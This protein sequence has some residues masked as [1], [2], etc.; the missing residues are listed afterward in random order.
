MD[1]VVLLCVD[2]GESAIGAAA[3]G[4]ARL[5]P[6]ERTIVV[7]VVEGANMPSE[8]EAVQQFLEHNVLF[9]PGKAA[10][11]GG[12]ATSG[13]EMAQNAGFTRWTREMV[14]ER[15]L[16]IM[17]NIHQSCIEA[18]VEYGRPGNYVVGANIAGFRR[19]AQAMLDQGVV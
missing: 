6:G 10:N 18:A 8:P 17:V 11:A 13:L 15:L 7:T 9:G 14:D 19:V 1:Q 3:T 5:A 16:G 2:G 4:L 12:V